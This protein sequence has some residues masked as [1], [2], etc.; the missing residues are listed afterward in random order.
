MYKNRKTVTESISKKVKKNHYLFCIWPLKNHL[1]SY[2]SS[3]LLKWGLTLKTSSWRLNCGTLQMHPRRQA[4]SLKPAK[5]KSLTAVVNWDSKASLMLLLLMMPPLNITSILVENARIYQ[6]LP[7]H[8]WCK[9]R[10]INNLVTMHSKVTARPVDRGE[11]QG[12]R[13]YA[14]H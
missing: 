2:L 12:N 10:D 3:V 11:A 1:K 6:T 7:S 13:K 8:L 5:S 4:S 9:S 14:R